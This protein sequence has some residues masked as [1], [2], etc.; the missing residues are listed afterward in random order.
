[1]NWLNR[2]LRREPDAEAAPE[3]GR[4]CSHALLTP[5]WDDVANVGDDSKA[6]GFTCSSCGEKFTP[7]E[8][9]LRSTDGRPP[10]G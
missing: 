9:A 8:A 6:S 7:A 5:Q 4:E 2:L 10:G 3:S 1:M